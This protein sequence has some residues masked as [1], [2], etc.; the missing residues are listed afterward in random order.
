MSF[1]NI[2][3]EDIMQDKFKNNLANPKNN[4][5]KQEKLALLK[6]RKETFLKKKQSKINEKK[7][8]H[9]PKHLL[10]HL[11]GSPRFVCTD[12]SKSVESVLEKLNSKTKLI[13]KT[14]RENNKKHKV[15][16]LEDN[17]NDYTFFT[18]DYGFQLHPSKKRYDTYL[19]SLYNKKYELFKQ[20]IQRI[21]DEV[22]PNIND[23]NITITPNGEDYA[24][25]MASIIKRRAKEGKNV[26][27]A[28]Y[29]EQISNQGKSF[30]YITL[31]P[32]KKSSDNP[33]RIFSL[34]DTFVF[35]DVPRADGSRG[36]GEATT[37]RYT[38]ITRKDTFGIRFVKR[39]LLF[40]EY[41]ID[42]YYDMFIEVLRALA[43]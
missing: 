19:L 20:A 18:K 39:E 14:I 29:L 24:V 43:K 6:Q 12:K 32:K 16:I 7:P 9:R 1:K 15:S 40:K 13:Q 27:R 11:V 26:T 38:D 17:F 41:I 36:T 30:M 22:I 42:N 23:Y 28:D 21:K 4:S 10:D 5:V 31:E 25:K 35:Y 34:N 3:M 8:E 33:P 2:F 37:L